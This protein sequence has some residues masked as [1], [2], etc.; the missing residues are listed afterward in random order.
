M[1]EKEKENEKVMEMEME[2]D[3]WRKHEGMGRR[4]MD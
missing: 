3:M 2:K 4:R 1:R